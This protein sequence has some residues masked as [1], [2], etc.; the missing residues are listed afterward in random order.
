MSS[1]WVRRSNLSPMKRRKEGELSAMT[2]LRLLLSVTHLLAQALGPL[3]AGR[4]PELLPDRVQVA[5]QN[6]GP[7]VQAR[8]RKQDRRVEK[9]C[10][11]GPV[12]SLLH[13]PG[14]SEEHTSELQSQS[15]LVC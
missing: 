8:D 14:R 13:L 7:T 10:R 5:G 15:N 2:R 4:D 1:R 9:S 12:A 3:R 11:L 6:R